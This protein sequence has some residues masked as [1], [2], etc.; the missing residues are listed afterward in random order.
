[1]SFRPWCRSGL[2]LLGPMSFD[3]MAF[4]LM[5]FVANVVMSRWND[6]RLNDIRDWTTPDWMTSDRTTAD[7]T[8]SDWMASGSG[9]KGHQGLNNIGTDQHQVPN[10]IN[11][12][13]FLPIFSQTFPWLFLVF[14]P[15]FTNS[16]GRNGFVHHS[17][18]WSTGSVVIMW[19]SC[20]NIQARLGS[21]CSPS[22]HKLGLGPLGL[23]SQSV[24]HNKLEYG[25][26]AG[27]ISGF[28]LPNWAVEGPGA[29]PTPP[30]PPNQSFPWLLYIQVMYHFQCTRG[31]GDPA[32][33]WHDG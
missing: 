5:L 8:T 20:A 10:D 21:V 9:T 4:G 2:V 13:K 32:H 33:K 23:L 1:M 6:I 16:S 14:S 19:C 17:G 11:G 15:L 29:T 28:Q 25:T 24:Y 31:G 12:K 22:A 27:W 7:R 26:V 18:S 30:H 3:L